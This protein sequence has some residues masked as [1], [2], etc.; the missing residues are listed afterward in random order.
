M[1][2][3]FVIAVFMITATSA[4]AL[5]KDSSYR[6][7]RKSGALAKIKIHI[8][9]DL[10]HDVSN[11]DISVF[12]GMNFRPNGY[13]LKGVTD[14]NGMF[15]AEGETCGDEILIDVR[16]H[17]FYNSVKKLCFAKM[18]AEHK[19]KDNKW[20][21][22]N[23]IEKITLRKIEKP[24]TLTAFNKL[25]DVAYTNKWIGFDM[26]N[27]DFINPFGC[28][29]NKDFEIKVE[30]DGLP[31]WKSKSCSMDVRFMQAETGGLYVNNV[32][33]SEFPYIYR[34][35]PDAIYGRRFIRIVNRNGDPYVTAIP[36]AQDSALVTRTR[37]VIDANG[38]VKAA[39]FGCIRRL[40]I[41]PS[42]RGVALLRLS[43]I[44]NPTPNDTNLEPKR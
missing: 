33:E 42:R 37:C 22:F 28:G 44:F 27:K 30:W 34:A 40:E 15:I 6:E 29:K 35:Q 16:K 5:S 25:I 14:T 24:I 12:F 21:P 36:F 3:F 31:A 10:G 23:E 26:E 7:A 17:G 32:L 13:Y 1:K 9:D 2:K 11:A 19:V 4:F 8:V 20:L 39:N 41:S 43:Y 38:K 18:G